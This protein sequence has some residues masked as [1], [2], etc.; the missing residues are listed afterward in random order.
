LSTSKKTLFKLKA[1][2]GLLTINFGL[3]TVDSQAQNKAIKSAPPWEAQARIAQ[4]KLAKNDHLG[5][6]NAWSEIIEKYPS[7]YEPLYQRAL[8]LRTI[9]DTAGALD[10]LDKAL[11][12]NGNY[13]SALIQRAILKH[14]IN[15]IKPA[16]ADIERAVTLAPKSYQAY[17][18]R[19][20]IKYVL[21]DF[22][23]AFSDYN[24]AVALNPELGKNV[25]KLV[26]PQ[27]AQINTP[28]VQ[29]SA[30]TYPNKLNLD[31]LAS[32]FKFGSGPNAGSFS[33]TSINVPAGNQSP[34]NASNTGSSTT[35]SGKATSTTNAITI[36]TTTGVATR[37]RSNQPRSNSQSISNSFNN[38]ASASDTGSTVATDLSVQPQTNAASSPTEPANDETPAQLAHHNN[39]AAQAINN[40]EFARAVDI[41]ERLLANHP[42]YAHAR[43]NLVIAHNNWGLAQAVRK[44][45]LAAQQ[46]RAALFVDSTQ[47]AARRNLNSLITEIGKDPH[48]PQDRMALAEQLLAQNDR[49]GAYV[50]AAEACRIRNTRETRQKLAQ[51]IASMDSADTSVAEKTAVIAGD[52]AP[53][54]FEPAK[55]MPIPAGK[56]AST[57]TQSEIQAQIQ[58]QGQ[59][60]PPAQAQSPVQSQAPADPP[61][62]VN[63]IIAESPSS[64][65]DD[66]APDMDMPPP[67]QA[68]DQES[69]KSRME[70]APEEVFMVAKQFAA[71]GNY[72]DAEQLLLKLTQRQHTAGD[73]RME[74]LNES[75]LETLVSINQKL[76][77]FDKAELHLRQLVKMQE[78]SRPQD[79]PHLGK[80]L[81][82]Y[83]QALRANGKEQEALKQETRANLIL[84]RISARE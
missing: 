28:H 57:T 73:T 82:E 80:T 55:E 40:K 17:V 34:A 49:A 64:T 74:A 25:N 42:D 51:V 46:F 66:S 36:N 78:R 61:I 37:T 3:V 72:I 81:A 67:V 76:N 5:A 60:P 44:P 38:T 7:R 39:Q 13:A 70:S 48:N 62:T 35:D 29:G 6:I 22:Q 26:Q 15:D 32:E 24:T 4:Q 11:E 84:G 68:Y 47:A 30:Q 43:D 20:S 41:L 63:N 18:E 14:K 54:K 75:I 9:G 12:I 58:T 83:A 77:R 59:A 1:I 71:E 65:P 21:G 19:S 50:E 31:K 79:D 53:T 52:K 8:I 23:G 56:Q 45:E 16:L 69:I 10:D 33:S 2:V 27:S